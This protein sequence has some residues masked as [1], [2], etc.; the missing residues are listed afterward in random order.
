MT[1]VGTWRAARAAGGMSGCSTIR[2][3]SSRLGTA[4]GSSR[5][6]RERSVSQSSWETPAGRRWVRVRMPQAVTWAQ[7]RLVS[8]YCCVPVPMVT[9]TGALMVAV[10]GIA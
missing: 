3:S 6:K 4:L 9:T 10:A 8:E 7:Q 5:A 1:R 2:A